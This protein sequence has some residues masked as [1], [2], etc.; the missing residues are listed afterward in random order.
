MQGTFSVFAL[1]GAVMGEANAINSENIYF[2]SKSIKRSTF[3]SAKC[4][5]TLTISFFIALPTILIL[6]GIA[7]YESMVNKNNIFDISRGEN[8]YAIF[9]SF[10]AILVF[11]SFISTI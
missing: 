11:S 9:G 6:V 3:L 2:L 7:S 10:L 4:L 8:S 5:S 1:I